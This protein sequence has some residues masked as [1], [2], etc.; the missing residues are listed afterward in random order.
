MRIDVTVG[1]FLLPLREK[2]RMRG[3]A[4]KTHVARRFVQLPA[5]GGTTLT[6][7]A[8]PEP[9][10][11]LPSRERECDAKQRNQT[12]EDDHAAAASSSGLE[13]AVRLRRILR[14]VRRGDTEGDEPV[15]SLL[16][17]PIK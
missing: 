5:S 9:V 12:L 15:L 11:G 1:Q 8:R 3:W 2:V 4:C 17:E 6:C 13:A 16:P 14:R 7:A 10:E